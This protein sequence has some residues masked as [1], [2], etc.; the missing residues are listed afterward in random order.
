M[1][2]PGIKNLGDDVVTGALT[3]EVITDG[4]LNGA[5]VE[6][7]GNLAGMTSVTVEVDFNW[8]SGGTTCIF[9]ID[10]SL[11]QGTNWIN[12]ARL[13]FA[14]ANDLKVVNLSAAAAAAVAS[15]TSDLGAEGKRDGILG[16]RLRC[17]RT[18]TGTY[19]NTSA[20]V[21]AAVR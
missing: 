12:I 8:G 21:R 11:D 15:L 5:A 14:T 18:S 19:A 1:N 6:Y 3:G 20:A 7:I 16:D 9:L 2:S 4:S 17:R 10:T 13:D